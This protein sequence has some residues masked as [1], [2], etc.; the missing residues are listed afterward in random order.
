MT[1]IHTQ[2]LIINLSPNSHNGEETTLTIHCLSELTPVDMLDMSY[3]RADPTGCCV[4]LG[5]FLFIEMF[6]RELCDTDQNEMQ[7]YWSKI[8]DALFPPNACALMELGSGTGMSSLSLLSMSTRSN[9]ED[10]DKSDAANSISKSPSLLVQTDVNDDALELCRINRDAN[11]DKI[12]RCA[13]HVEKLEWGKDTTT[14]LNKA[15]LPTTYHTVLATDVLYDLSSLV[16]LLTSAFELLKEDGYFILS[17]VPRAYMDED[18]NDSETTLETII[19]KEAFKVGLDL[20]AYPCE[21][22][23]IGEEIIQSIK[24]QNN[25]MI[26]RPSLLPHIFGDNTVSISEKYS[27]KRMIDAGTAVF[28]FQKKRSS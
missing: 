23:D 7:K 16:P 11:K 13:V 2:P 4:W 14:I 10:T 3:G 21:E 18:E 8:R 20:A 17:H 9:E 22:K 12:R 1:S 25:T 24:E 28:V 15:N 26:L 27:W 6:A 19:I 5:A